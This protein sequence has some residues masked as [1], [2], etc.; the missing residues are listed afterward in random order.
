MGLKCNGCPS[1]TFAGE[2]CITCMHMQP[3]GNAPLI[4]MAVALTQV[5]DACAGPQI[6][7]MQKGWP[8]QLCRQV[9][10]ERAH[11]RRHTSMHHAI[12]GSTR[13]TQ[14]AYPYC[15]VC[16]GI[17][18][19]CEDL[20]TQ[21]QPPGHADLKT[22]NPAPHTQA[23]R[24]TTQTVSKL[25]RGLGCVV[26]CQCSWGTFLRVSGPRGWTPR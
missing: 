1:G 19:S 2:K 25:V 5:D 12:M 26:G 24:H 13:L 22:C 20:T 15:G 10:Q 4:S 6:T 11:V 7:Q 17:V 18:R 14:A 3:K 21:P 23:S 9:V 16:M 8:K